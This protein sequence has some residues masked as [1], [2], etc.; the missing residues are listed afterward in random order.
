MKRRTLVSFA[1]FMALCASGAFWAT[2]FFK[3]AER[4]VLAPPPPV[5]APPRM[6]SAASLFGATAQAAVASN[7]QLKGVIM[8][9]TAEDSV[10]I[11]SADGKPAQAVR[12][13]S[14]IEP[15]VKVVAVH[16]RHVILSDR[17]VQKRVDLP[18]EAASPIEQQTGARSTPL[19]R[20][21]LALPA[22]NPNSGVT[23]VTTPQT[24]P[25]SPAGRSLQPRVNAPTSAQ[26]QGR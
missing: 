1:L 25:V 5:Q 12:A 17:G 20:V 26:Q 11:L 4:P 3:P 24:A 10:A 13:N 8:S 19:P 9:G 23:V 14:E 22:G 6:E 2:Q 18:Q 16:R 7:F 21:Q 15:G